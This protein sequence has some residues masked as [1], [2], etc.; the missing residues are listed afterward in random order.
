M[1]RRNRR[2]GRGGMEDHGRRL[3]LR[4]TRGG[5][6]RSCGG[7]TGLVMTVMAANH[8]DLGRISSRSHGKPRH[9]QHLI[10]NPSRSRTCWGRRLDFVRGRRTATRRRGRICQGPRAC[11]CLVIFFSVAQKLEF[12]RQGGAKAVDFWQGLQL[13][14]DAFPPRLL[15]QTRRRR[16]VT[17]SS[18]Q[19]ILESS[20]IEVHT[21][22]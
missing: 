3:A 14:G 2:G 18:I 9:L 22:R 13:K 15:I 7:S 12:L 1:I 16:R 6:G 21:P 8:C 20:H 10:G 11:G 5:S 4:T 17:A 19:V